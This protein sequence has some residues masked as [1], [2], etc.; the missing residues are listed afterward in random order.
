MEKTLPNT[1]WVGKPAGYIDLADKCLYAN[2]EACN[3]DPC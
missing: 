2:Y 1:L 3:V